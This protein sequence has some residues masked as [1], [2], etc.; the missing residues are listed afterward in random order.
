LRIGRLSPKSV[1]LPRHRRDELNASARSPPSFSKVAAVPHSKGERG[2]QSGSLARR[3]YEVKLVSGETVTLG[4]SL[5]DANDES[6]ARLKREHGASHM[7]L[8]IVLG[9]PN[10]LEEVVLWFQQATTLTLLSQNGDT[11][12]G[13]EVKILLP[14]YFTV[15]FDEIKDVAPELANITLAAPKTGDKNLH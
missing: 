12:I 13:D 8:L 14:R 1:D 6:M 5:A 9:D 4:F 7:G 11:M 10:S 2:R 3:Q 15:F